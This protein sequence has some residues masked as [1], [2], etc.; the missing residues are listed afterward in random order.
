MPDPLLKTGLTGAVIAAI[1]CF[2]PILVWVFG[3]VGLGALVVYL[4]LILLPAFGLFLFLT[5]YALWR[6]RK[7]A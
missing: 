2:T 6:R 1:C 5:G 7:A 4:D 3:A